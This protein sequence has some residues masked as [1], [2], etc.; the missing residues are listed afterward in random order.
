MSSLTEAGRR[1]QTEALARALAGGEFR[2]VADNDVVLT[3]ARFGKSFTMGV[4]EFS[5]GKFET[6][7]AVAKGRAARFHCYAP[8]GGEALLVG[9]IGLPPIAKAVDMVLDDTMFY[10]G[11]TFELEE[12][13]HTRG[14]K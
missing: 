5:F 6:V 14:R 2:V 11:M 9:S 1:L 7:K 4:D 3:K 10:E 8:G 13:T 12:F